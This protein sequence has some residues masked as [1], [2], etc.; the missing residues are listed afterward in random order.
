MRTRKTNKKMSIKNLAKKALKKRQM[1]EEKKMKKN[2]MN[3]INNDAK[4]HKIVAIEGSVSAIVDR[5]I[6]LGKELIHHPRLLDDMVRDEVLKE[7]ILDNPEIVAQLLQIPEVADNVAREPSFIVE[8]LRDAS[9]VK[10]LTK[11]LS[12]SSTK[13]SDSDPEAELQLIELNKDLMEFYVHKHT[14]DSF[15][16]TI[17]CCIFS[18]QMRIICT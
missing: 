8:I 18:L 9:K 3:M 16:I 13:P 7:E 6:P 5:M 12:K 2:I 15:C 14:F 17:L 1:V 10:S 11:S 4:L